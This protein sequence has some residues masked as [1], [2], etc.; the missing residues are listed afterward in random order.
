MSENKL[1]PIYLK[2]DGKL[3]VVVG[4]G[5]V[6]LQKLIGLINSE[7]RIVVI[8][9]TIIKEIRDLEG[10]FPFKRNIKFIER[11]YQFGDEK[12]AFMLIA[13]TDIP[14]LN[15]SIANRCRD[16]GVLVNSVDE[17]KYCDFYVPSIAQAGEL[18]IA[19]SSNGSAPSVSQKIR[20]DLEK[21]LEKKY[22]R[23]IPVIRE[24][25]AVVHTRIPGQENFA[26]RAKLIRWYTDRVFKKLDQEELINV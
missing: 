15:S 7:A 5:L 3:V 2:L 13:A 25:R 17:P 19:I 21:L 23:L 20:K 14:G 11:E 9:P 24:F 10:E 8:A 1:Y 16:Q 22:S 6:A 4:G 18:K 12:D 26:R